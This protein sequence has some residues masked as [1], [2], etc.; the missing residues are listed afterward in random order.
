MSKEY[1]LMSLRHSI[2]FDLCTLIPTRHHNIIISENNNS[3]MGVA[4]FF[5]TILDV[6]VNSQLLLCFLFYI[7]FLNIK[8]RLLTVAP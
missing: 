8:P 2:S 6:N 7:F 1:D 5:F 4:L 3:I